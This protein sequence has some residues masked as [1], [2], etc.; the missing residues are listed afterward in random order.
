MIVYG[1]FYNIAG[2]H[3]YLIPVLEEITNLRQDLQK[4]TSTVVDLTVKVNE[5]ERIIKQKRKQNK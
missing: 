1:A 5:I 4:V 3:K 2:S